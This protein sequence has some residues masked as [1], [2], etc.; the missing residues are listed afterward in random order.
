MDAV[1]QPS[2]HQELGIEEALASQIDGWISRFL[3][4]FDMS[5]IDGIW[6]EIVNI[7]WRQYIYIYDMYTIKLYIDSKNWYD[8]NQYD[9]ILYDMYI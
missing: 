5:N 1:Q 7:A 2:S 9:M 4:V 6:N 3:A 8:M